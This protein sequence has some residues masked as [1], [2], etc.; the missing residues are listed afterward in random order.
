[1]PFGERAAGPGLQIAFE[2]GGTRLVWKLYRHDHPPGSMALRVPTWTFVVPRES[3]GDV[4]GPSD[5]MAIGVTLASQDVDESRPDASHDKGQGH[6]ARQDRLSGNAEES[7]SN[8]WRV[9]G[10]RSSG[11]VGR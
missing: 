2:A 4:G 6:V 7:C 11:W 10:T 1:M 9:R 5:V 8:E 3:V